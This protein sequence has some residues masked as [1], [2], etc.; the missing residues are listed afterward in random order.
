MLLGFLETLLQSGDFRLALASAAASN[1]LIAREGRF[2]VARLRMLIR[3]LS[4]AICSTRFCARSRFAFIGLTMSPKGLSSC[5]A[6][7]HR[8]A[9]PNRPP[10]PRTLAALIPSS[11]TSAFGR[12]VGCRGCAGSPPGKAVLNL[13]VRRTASLYSTPV[14][15]KLF[16]RHCPPML[17]SERVRQFRVLAA[18][19]Q[20]RFP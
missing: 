14:G 18:V 15:L 3:S 16:M 6:K 20:R 9:N 5:A 4:P 10:E 2:M 1:C 19:E 7:N 17:A 12:G 11:E 8:P 13:P